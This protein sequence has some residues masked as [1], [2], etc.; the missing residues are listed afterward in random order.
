MFFCF[1]HRLPWQ[2]ISGNP[3]I[4]H[5]QDCFATLDFPR[6]ISP[7]WCLRMKW[8]NRLPLPRFAHVL[9]WNCHCL[10]KIPNQ[11]DPARFLFV[12]WCQSA[13]YAVVTSISNH[14]GDFKSGGHHLGAP[15]LPREYGLWRTMK[16]TTNSNVLKLLIIYWFLPLNVHIP[17]TFFRKSLFIL[18]YHCKNIS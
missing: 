11:T 18:H 7:A 5:H 17:K 10:W 13:A 8:L 1:Y 16:K 2:F 15:E 3:T 9:G 4:K 6:T 12:A 14:C